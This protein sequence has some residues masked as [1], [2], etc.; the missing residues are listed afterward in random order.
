MTHSEET[1]SPDEAPPDENTSPR[2][3]PAPDEK[4]VEETEEDLDKVVGN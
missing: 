1:Q 2:D 3:N 4:K